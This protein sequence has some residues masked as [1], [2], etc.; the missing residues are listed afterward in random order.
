MTTILAAVAIVLF[1]ILI[2][3]CVFG[4]FLYQQEK[5]NE[6]K[7]EIKSQP[8]QY[9]PVADISSMHPSSC[10]SETPFGYRYNSYPTL[11]ES[12]FRN[13]KHR[14]ELIEKETIDNENDMTLVERVKKLEDDVQE[15]NQFYYIP[16]DSDDKSLVDMYKDLEERCNKLFQMMSDR[17]MDINDLR[18][19]YEVLKSSYPRQTG[20]K[21]TVGDDPNQMQNGTTVSTAETIPHFTQYRRT[22][23]YAKAP[24]EFCK[25]RFKTIEDA[26]KVAKEMRTA[27]EQNGYCSVGRYL[28]FS[29][30]KANSEDFNHGWTDL[31]GV[32][33]KSGDDDVY[34]YSLVLPE[35]EEL[36]EEEENG[37]QE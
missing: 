12:S 30:G 22:I 26:K 14:M 9:H 18:F 36:Y 20:Y 11:S 16:S 3:V 2:A 19:K 31:N 37:L 32:Y 29:G 15:L 8:G 4:F 6:R 7:D 34:P 28:E 5:W 24:Y 10:V 1:A 21:I 23:P 17:I 35:P 13:L 25:I 33:V 27:I